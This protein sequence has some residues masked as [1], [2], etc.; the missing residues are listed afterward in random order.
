MNQSQSNLIIVWN[1]Y[2]YGKLMLIFP[3]ICRVTLECYE[4]NQH[5]SLSHL[6]YHQPC[7]HSELHPSCVSTLLPH[8]YT[9]DEDH[10]HESVTTEIASEYQLHSFYSNEQIRTILTGT[11][12]RKTFCKISMTLSFYKTS[13]RPRMSSIINLNNKDGTSL[14]ILFQMSFH[15]KGSFWP[16]WKLSHLHLDFS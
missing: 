1:H 3:S 10:C 11:F 2:Y 14:D 4:H 12:A 9:S 13:K 5:R 16:V 15:Q 7:L 6:P 8:R